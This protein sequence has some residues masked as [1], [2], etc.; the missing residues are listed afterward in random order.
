[1]DDKDYIQLILEFFLVIDLLN[2]ME[3]Q[4]TKREELFIYFFKK[5]NKKFT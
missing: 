4:E 5:M 2:Q 3:L 1:M